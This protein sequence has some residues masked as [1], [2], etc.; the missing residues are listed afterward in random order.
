M[1]ND[2]PSIARADAIEQRVLMLPSTGADGIAMAKL[3][4]ANRIAFAICR[5]M[6]KLC[7][8][9]REGAGVLLVVRGGDFRRPL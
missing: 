5:S 8:M 3:F 1:Q 4:D 9:H 2:A 6:P 7:E